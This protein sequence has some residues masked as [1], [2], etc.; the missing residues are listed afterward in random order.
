MVE[1]K[2]LRVTYCGVHMRAHM[3]VCV[4]IF[5]RC[6][7]CWSGIWCVDKAGLKSVAVFIFRFLN[8]GVGGMCYY[9]F[10]HIVEGELIVGSSYLVEEIVLVVAGS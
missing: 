10:A 2:Q 7:S 5:L 6:R 8:A 3:P 9:P 1:L 4:C